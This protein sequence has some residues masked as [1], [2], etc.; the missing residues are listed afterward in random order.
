M[1]TSHYELV[2][3]VVRRFGVPGHAADDAAQQVFL[4]AAERLDDIVVASER[5]FLY[6]TAIRVAKAQRRRADREPPTDTVDERRAS[7]PSPEA[8]TEL[9]RARALLD[10]V[11]D[12][13]GDDI[14][15]VFV[16]HELES[17]TMREIAEILG[18]P[19]GTVASRLR[20]AREAFRE[21]VARLSAAPGE[22][23]GVR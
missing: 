22:S 6:G 14:R 17:L 18:L 12:E 10:R 16:L 3:R 8:E 7:G 4:V 11:L 13:L 9:R 5:S 20:R 23:G 19:P 21:Q 1:F 15:E 2:W